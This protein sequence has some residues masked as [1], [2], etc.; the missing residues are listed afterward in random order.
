MMKGNK[1]LYIYYKEHIHWTNKADIFIAWLR[2][3]TVELDGPQHFTQVAN[4]RSPELQHQQDLFKTKC[5]N[6]NGYSVIRVLQTDVVNEVVDFD[7][8][9][10]CIE[11]KGIKNKII[12]KNKDL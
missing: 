7:Y 4:W 9:V 11:E 6:E 3:N 10:S 5:A 12:C 2:H 1:Y 8:L